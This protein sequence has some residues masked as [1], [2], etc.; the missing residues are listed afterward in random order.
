MIE[1]L[2]KKESNMQETLALHFDLDKRGLHERPGGSGGNV[3]SAGKKRQ[4]TP[5][6]PFQRTLQHAALRGLVLEQSERN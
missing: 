5:Q 6:P 1:D 2:K 3:N 4:K